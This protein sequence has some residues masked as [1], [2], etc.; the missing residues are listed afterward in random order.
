MTNG[1][2]QEKKT[3]MTFLKS[4]GPNGTKCKP[5]EWARCHNAGNISHNLLIEAYH[6]VIKHYTSRRDRMDEALNKLFRFNKRTR[7]L[8]GARDLAFKGKLLNVKYI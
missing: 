4:Y 2:E 3:W 6:S 7:H 8:N 1:T 5:S